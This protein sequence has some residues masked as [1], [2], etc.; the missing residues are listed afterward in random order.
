MTERGDAAVRV[1]RVRGAARQLDVHPNT[2]RA[3]IREGK[4]EAVRLPNGH[5]RITD[6]AIRDLLERGTG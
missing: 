2:L 4:L 3:W 6:R 5:W 1:F